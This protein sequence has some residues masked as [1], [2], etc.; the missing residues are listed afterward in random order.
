MRSWRRPEPGSGRHPAFPGS[1]W[2]AEWSDSLPRDPNSVVSELRGQGLTF[3]EDS[4]EDL[5]IRG[6]SWFLAYAFCIWDDARLPTEAEWE[7]SCRAGADVREPFTFERPSNSLSSTLANFENAFWRSHLADN[8]S[9]EQWLEAGSNEAAFEEYVEWRPEGAPEARWL[10]PSSSRR[11]R[12]KFA[13]AGAGA[14][15]GAWARCCCSTR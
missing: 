8:N 11:L 15:A 14:W 3:G 2:E 4:R 7:Y 1:G 5:P 10:E 12:V 9:F 13:G 6:V